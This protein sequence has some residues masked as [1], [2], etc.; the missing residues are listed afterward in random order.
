MVEPSKLSRN[1]LLLTVPPN[2]VESLE[3]IRDSY[4]GLSERETLTGA[5][6]G[7]F[8]AVEITLKQLAIARGSSRSDAFAL[9]AVSDYP[10]GRRPDLRSGTRSD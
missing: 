9:R 2:A 10:R 6:Q 7:V 4:N 5:D 1:V 3:R 8:A